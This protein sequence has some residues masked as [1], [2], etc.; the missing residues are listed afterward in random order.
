MI[1]IDLAAGLIREDAFPFRNGQG[2]ENSSLIRLANILTYNDLIES[3]K[4]GDFNYDNKGINISLDNFGK[5]TNTVG[6]RNYFCKQPVLRVFPTDGGIEFVE[7]V[8]VQDPEHPRYKCVLHVPEANVTLKYSSRID[9]E[10]ILKALK[11]EISQ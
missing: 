2:K 10:K 4:I 6:D 9:E 3:G 1:E 5:N 11:G 7:G 8:S